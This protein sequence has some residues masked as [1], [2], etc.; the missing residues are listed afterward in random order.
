MVNDHNPCEDAQHKRSAKNMHYVW[1]WYHYIFTE[2]H[3]DIRNGNST[4]KYVPEGRTW[5]S[6]FQKQ[7]CHKWIIALEHGAHGLVHWQLRWKQ[8]NLETKEQ[9]LFSTNSKHISQKHISNLQKTGVIMKGKKVTLS[10]AMTLKPSIRF[11]CPRPLQRKRNTGIVGI[12]IRQQIDVWYDPRGNHGKSWLTI[13]LFG[14]K[15]QAFPVF[16]RR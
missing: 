7:D 6:Y 15:G 9:T 1:E 10:Q 5:L 8:R 3:N 16:T 4:K 12:T 14:K 2:G 13:H 11:G